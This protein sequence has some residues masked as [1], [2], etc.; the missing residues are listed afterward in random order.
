M[1]LDLPLRGC[2]CLAGTGVLCCHQLCLLGRSV[3]GDLRHRTAQLHV[4]LLVRAEL[5]S[6][7][8]LPLSGRGRIVAA[9]NLGGRQLCLHDRH[10]PAELC[11]RAAQLAVDPL[12]GLQL[13]PQLCLALGGFCCLGLRLACGHC[14]VSH[15]LVELALQPT[16]ALLPRCDSSLR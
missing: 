8:G 2:G 9:G 6:Q 1:Q 10:V 12:G 5:L 13:L 16:L 15:L 7:L 14:G 4:G 11:H 3:S